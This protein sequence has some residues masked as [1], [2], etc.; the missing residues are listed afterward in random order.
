MTVD[1]ASTRSWRLKR[2]SS[3]WLNTQKEKT[4]TS[5]HNISNTLQYET[6]PETNHTDLEGS[7][8]HNK[9]LVK[10]LF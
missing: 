6:V 2:V 4:G 8:F 9:N 1:M 7:R 10:T 5:L 3:H